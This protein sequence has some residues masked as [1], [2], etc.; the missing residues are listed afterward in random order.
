MPWRGEPTVT[1]PIRTRKLVFVY[2]VAGIRRD[3]AAT[4]VIE[5][6]AEALSDQHSTELALLKGALR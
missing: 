3:Y 4:A 6:F 1:L 2:A 5:T